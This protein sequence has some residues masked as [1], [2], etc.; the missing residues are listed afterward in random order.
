MAHPS[1][2]A[3]AGTFFVTAITDKDMPVIEGVVLL[4]VATYLI[5][6]L[7]SDIVIRI[8]DPRILTADGPPKGRMR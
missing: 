3:N 5:L 4:I 8:I 6:N 2:T 7:L 1:R